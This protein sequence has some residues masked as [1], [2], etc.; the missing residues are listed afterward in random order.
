MKQSVKNDFVAAARARRYGMKHALKIAQEA[1]RAG[2]PYDLAYAKIE[3]ESGN[4]SNVFGHDR[5][6][7][8]N[9]IFPARPGTVYVTKKLYDEYK[10]RRRN[11]GLMQGV[12]PSQLT[13]WEY[14]DAA[15]RAGGCWKPRYNIRTGFRLLRSLIKQYGTAEGVRRYN[16]SGPRAEAYKRSVLERRVKWRRRLNP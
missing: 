15:D 13:W 12:G 11:T 4:G 10:R 6:S 3:Q 5:D 2:I 8:G 9:L 16:G 1:R 14:Q 7:R